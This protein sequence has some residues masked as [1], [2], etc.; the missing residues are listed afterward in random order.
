MSKILMIQA[1]EAAE[2]AYK[3]GVEFA[4]SLELDS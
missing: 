1:F 2:A 3:K 4:G